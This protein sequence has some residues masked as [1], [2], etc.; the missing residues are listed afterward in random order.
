[1][2]MPSLAESWSPA[3]LECAAT[4]GCRRVAEGPE[5][6]LFYSDRGALSIERGRERP[7]PFRQVALFVKAQGAPVAVGGVSQG[8]DFAAR[9]QPLVRL[10]SR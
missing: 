10:P 5:E 3:R 4:A 2:R 9:H 1:M 7:K 8:F 6:C